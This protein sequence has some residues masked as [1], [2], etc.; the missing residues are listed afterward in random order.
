MIITRS[1][2]RLEMLPAAYILFATPLQLPRQP[3]QLWQ[4]SALA[5]R[6]ACKDRLT[7][8]V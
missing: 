8:W 7:P 3:G 4:S 5:S 1:G 2:V 6:H